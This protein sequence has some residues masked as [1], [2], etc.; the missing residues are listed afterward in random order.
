M[1]QHGAERRSARSPCGLRLLPLGFPGPLAD[2]APPP[3]LMFFVL[4]MYTHP[5][6][7]SFALL[8]SLLLSSI[9]CEIRNIPAASSAQT[10]SVAHKFLLGIYELMEEGEDL[11]VSQINIW[12][13]TI[14]GCGGERERTFDDWRGWLTSLQ[15]VVISLGLQLVSASAAQ[16]MAGAS[17]TTQ[18]YVPVALILSELEKISSMIGTA[19]EAH[20]APPKCWAPKCLFDMGIAHSAVVQ[21]Y[22]RVLGEIDGSAD[23]TP[24]ELGP[25]RTVAGGISASAADI[26]TATD[27]YKLQLVESSLAVVVEWFK[28][29]MAHS[30]HQRQGS[31]VETSELW[32]FLE[33]G[34]DSATGAVGESKSTDF[35][36]YRDSPR[37]QGSQGGPSKLDAFL[38]AVDHTLASVRGTYPALAALQKER[39][40]INVLEKQFISNR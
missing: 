15:H 27:V 8:S 25:S 17:G 16:P 23:V 29:T 7:L 39:K 10:A 14:N 13:E 33:K 36:V 9:F 5:L 22:T 18:T 24:L 3:N 30:L 20:N 34:G 37:P 21:A 6:F 2:I 12:W 35:S 19:C 32:Y 40:R 11:Y 38:D 28:H 4:C 1:Q 26:S 31:D